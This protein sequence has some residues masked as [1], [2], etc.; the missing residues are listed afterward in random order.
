M[1]TSF[2]PPPGVV[3]QIE[4]EISAGELCALLRR[5]AV[6]LQELE[7]SSP[8]LRLYHD[9]WE[10]DV[11]HFD[12][13]AITFHELFE[14]IETPRAVFDATPDEHAVFVGVAPEDARW[15][16]CFCAEWDAVQKNIVGRCAVILTSGLVAQFRNEVVVSEV[17][18]MV[19]ESSDR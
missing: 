19:E 10:H 9:W 18:R 4:D 8:R 13:R 11:L 6:F 14:M 1:P 5:V 15:Y 16:L 3:F 12:E 7:P 2:S 17:H